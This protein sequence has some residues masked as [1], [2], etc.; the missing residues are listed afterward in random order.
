VS[1]NLTVYATF[2]K[3]RNYSH[4]VHTMD[5]QHEQVREREDDL[6]IVWGAAAIGKVI[7]RTPRQT[8]HMLKRGLIQA[9]R[10]CGGRWCADRAGLR[11]QFCG[12]TGG[13]A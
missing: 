10:Q 13:A 11:A 2:R 8:H 3:V 5:V 1:T 6:G 12:H 7:N 9:A 4:T